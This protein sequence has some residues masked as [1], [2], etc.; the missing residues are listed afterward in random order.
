[1]TITTRADATAIAAALAE[2]RA[3]LLDLLSPL[4]D[5]QLTVQHSPL[6]SPL[7][8]DLA[9]V[10]NYEDI[11]LV[12]ALGG[13]AVGAHLD[14]LY[15]AFRHPRRERPSLPLLSPAEARE[16]I[17]AVRSRALALLDAVDISPANRNP[18]LSNGF[19][20]GMVIQHEHQ[21]IETVLATLQLGGLLTPP[22]LE[23]VTRAGEVEIAGGRYEIGT[24]DD[25]WA[26]DNER[27]AH[28]VELAP[29]TIDRRPVTNADWQA[30]LDAGGWPEPPLFW[31]DTA[32]TRHPDA[33]VIH[34]S[35]EEADVY[36]RWRGRR[37]PTEQEWEVAARAGA[38]AGVGQVWEWTASDFLPWPG[39]RA[40]PYP[41]YSEVFCGS[42]YKVLRGSSWASHDCV[43][44]PTFRNWDYPIRRQIF[45]GLRTASGGR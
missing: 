28:G 45:A 11:W 29:F 31:H 35:W 38:L 4:T 33:P 13:E 17:G 20:F 24:S 37:L 8:W 36:A 7:V 40:F 34:V 39:F 15:D 25:A 44:R 2:S 3:R 30:F 1:M 12:R 41:E 42:E 26:Y 43:R 14:D 16:Y 5:E 23:P 18:L 21:H 22:P 27:P 19:V 32:A 10:G 9:H 6:M